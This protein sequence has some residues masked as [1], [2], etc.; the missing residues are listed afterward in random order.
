MPTHTLEDELYRMYDTIVS[1]TLSKLVKSAE[2]NG[3]IRLVW[4]NRKDKEHLFVLRIA[5][6]ARDL[7]NFPVEVNCKWFDRL[8]INWKIR[9]SFDK[10][11]KAP[12]FAFN[13]IWMYSFLENI[14]TEIDCP[15]DFGEVYDAYY[16]RS[17][18]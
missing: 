4:F 6:M 1:E 11:N 17:C 7:Y 13:G 18:D 16:E 3:V 15:I 14:H 10:V 2:E 9:K 8:C 5:L 12:D